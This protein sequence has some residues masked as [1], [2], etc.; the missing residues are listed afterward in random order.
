MGRQQFSGCISLTTHFNPRSGGSTSSTLHG[1]T[2]HKATISIKVITV[3]KRSLLQDIQFRFWLYINRYE[4]N[5]PFEL[6]I[7]QLI[8]KS[9]MNLEISCHIIKNGHFLYLSLCWER[10]LTDDFAS[11]NR[12]PS[13]WTSC[14]AIPD[15]PFTLYIYA[16]VS[17]FHIIIIT[18]SQ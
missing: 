4:F 11:K 17:M 1:A 13:S 15:R 9:I 10:I 2:K 6:E 12:S 18:I 8:L 5:A 3:L 16:C 7:L 14:L